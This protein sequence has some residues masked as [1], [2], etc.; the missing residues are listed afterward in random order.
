MKLNREFIIEKI[1]A[2]VEGRSDRD[3]VYRWALGTAVTEEFAHFCKEDA[4]AAKVVQ[5]LIDINHNDVKSIPTL[6][7]L[8]Y[9]KLCLKGEREYLPLGSIKDLD[10]VSPVGLEEDAAGLEIIEEGVKSLVERFSRGLRVFTLVFGAVIFFVSVF[11]V[12]VAAAPGKPGRVQAA[13]KIFAVLIYSV[14]VILPPSLIAKERSF[15]VAVPI[16][17]FGM[18]VSWYYS[19]NMIPGMFSSPVIQVFLSALI[20][21]PATIALIL[22]F[23]AKGFKFRRKQIDF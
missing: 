14:F 20:I 16:L 6:K 10:L 9:Y 8:V 1:D 3:A 12:F 23:R 4:V 2:L 13:F 18:I 22:L 7:A 5:T 19:L 17:L 21:V 15:F 11:F